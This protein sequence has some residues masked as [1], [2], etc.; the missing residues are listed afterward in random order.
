MPKKDC[1]ECCGTG[2]ITIFYSVSPCEACDGTGDGNAYVIRDG[3]N[4]FVGAYKYIWSRKHRSTVTSIPN[5]EHI[6][7][8]MIELVEF[9]NNASDVPPVP[10]STP[11]SP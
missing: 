3:S 8:L 11:S 9:A 1:T 5:N 7:A 2:K 4:P 10:P 6:T